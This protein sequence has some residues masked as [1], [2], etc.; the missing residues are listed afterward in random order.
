KSWRR[1][2]RNWSHARPSWSPNWRNPRLTRRRAK[3]TG[4]IGSWFR[5]RP[6]WPNC[7]RPG[8]NR[9]R[10]WLPWT[11]GRGPPAWSSNVRL[12]SGAE[13]CDRHVESRLLEMHHHFHVGQSRLADAIQRSVRTLE[14]QRVRMSLGPPCV[15]GIEEAGFDVSQQYF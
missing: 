8:S 7:T 15:A 11:E 12:R 10:G 13:N 2:S 1:R 14:I 3:L 5:S 6:A 4:S 9:Q